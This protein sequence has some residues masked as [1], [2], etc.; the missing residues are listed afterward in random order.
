MSDRWPASEDIDGFA[1][2]QLEAW[3]DAAERYSRLDGAYS[4]VMMLDGQRF[5]LQH[6][7]ARAVS[8]CADMDAVSTRPCFLCDNAR[9]PQQL[10]LPLPG[11]RFHLLL[12]PFPIFHPHF[13]VAATAHSP[14][15][16][17]HHTLEA[18]VGLAKSTEARY[19]WFYN[20]ARCGASA[21]DHLHFQGAPQDGIMP[22][23][24][25]LRE[26]PAKLLASR[27]RAIA[28]IYP[29]ILQKVVEI[30]G[31]E[32]DDVKAL[33]ERVIQSVP[34][35]EGEAE[36]RF[37]L[38]VFMR[39]GRL[40]VCVIIRGRH[41]PECYGPEGVLFSPG[42]VDMAGG[43]ILPRES[44]YRSLTQESLRSML[45]EVGPSDETYYRLILDVISYESE[46]Q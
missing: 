46:K 2:R 33:A 17:G 31:T 13:T 21:P 20:G 44:D 23:W 34:R 38:Y 7:P 39:D 43:I 28:C 3:P 18:M 6:N 10:S 30:R 4:R 40:H 35:H 12:N 36:G 16:L 24:E 25:N 26:A 32:D 27:G 22:I 41:R 14:Q 19:L 37:N 29:S 11:G 8:T 5:V 1:L 45:R 42:A 15:L 9:P